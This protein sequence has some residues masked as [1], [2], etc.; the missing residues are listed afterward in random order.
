MQ[1][2]RL[3]G[4]QELEPKVPCV[5]VLGFFDGVHLGHQA[6]L[7]TARRLANQHRLPVTVLVLNRH[8]SQVDRDGQTY[9]GYLNTLQQRLAHLN[10]Q[11]VDYAYLV[12][13]NRKFAAFSP[14]T[15]VANFVQGLNA[16]VV[17]AGFDY[18]F[19]RYG[20]AGLAEMQ[21]LVGAQ[22]KVVEVVR[23]NDHCEK[24]SS[25]RIRR[26]ICEG[27]IATANQLLGY[28][29]QLVGQLGKLTAEGCQ[30]RPQSSQQLL[31]A[32]GEYTG[33][34]ETSG[35]S[36]I[37]KLKVVPDKHQLS[38]KRVVIVT[39]LPINQSSIQLNWV[40][41]WMMGSLSTMVGNPDWACSSIDYPKRM[42]C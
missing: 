19:G 25:T 13:F 40:G 9:F 8:F 10:E 35:F 17:V 31:P 20:K 27:Q 28:D 12:D 22:I 34:V 3:N 26:L 6:V 7:A 14:A 36:Q 1:L 4:R 30:L 39:P 42:G 23:R 33:W 32:E 2:I 24:V 5:L 18:T 41:Q 38:G 37:I 16:Q 21:Q 29:Y 11:G 15:F